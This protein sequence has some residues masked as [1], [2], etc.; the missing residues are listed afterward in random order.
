MTAD[1]ILAA[2]LQLPADER[3]R[4]WT[5][6]RAAEG[7]QQ[8]SEWSQRRYRVVHQLVVERG[9]ATSGRGAWT[10]ILAILSLE[11]PEAALTRPPPRGASLDTV[12][13]FWII[14]NTISPRSLR[15][16]YRDWCRRHGY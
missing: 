12:A 11:C 15:V 2:A 3:R 16:G 7:R 14:R 5:A 13:P 9:L 8:R 10:R 1:A 4:L 6:I